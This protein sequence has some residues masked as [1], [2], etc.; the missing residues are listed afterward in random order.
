MYYLSLGGVDY[1]PEKIWNQIKQ[2]KKKDFDLKSS[3]EVNSKKYFGNEKSESEY[4]QYIPQ[5]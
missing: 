1:D 2:R 3:N 5:Y 4:F